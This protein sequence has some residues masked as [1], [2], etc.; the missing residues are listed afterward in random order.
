LIGSCDITSL[1]LVNCGLL[2][3][4][5]LETY[6]ILKC[7]ILRDEHKNG[8]ETV[9]ITESIKWQLVHVAV[10]VALFPPF[11]FFSALYYTDIA[12]LLF[13][14]LTYHA[15]I[16]GTK[17]SKKGFGVIFLQLFYAVLALLFR[18][19]NV[20]WVGVFP[21]GLIALEQFAKRPGVQ[22]GAYAGGIEGLCI[23][24]FHKF[25]FIDD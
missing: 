13:V 6:Q 11:F 4:V 18:Q 15:T 16:L 9:Q 1:R 12:S 2:S 8:R 22:N 3:L 5:A 10:N 25:K 23:T 7:L 14:L 17:P 19:T 24:I 21:I 20:F